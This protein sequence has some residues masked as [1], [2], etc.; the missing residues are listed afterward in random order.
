MIASN[1]TQTIADDRREKLAP[2]TRQSSIDSDQSAVSI[3]CDFLFLV[4]IVCLL[5]LQN[6]ILTNRLGIG[7]LV[8]VSRAFPRV[9]NY[10]CARFCS[11]W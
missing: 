4:K 6:L 11:V 10:F 7:S 3:N 8:N 2:S 9:K 5:I 1:D